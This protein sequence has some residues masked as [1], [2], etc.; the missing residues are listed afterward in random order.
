MNIELILGNAL[1]AF[2]FL[3]A[4]LNLAIDCLAIGQKPFILFVQHLEGARLITS[5]VLL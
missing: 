4:C 2:Q 1:A 3:D 5:S